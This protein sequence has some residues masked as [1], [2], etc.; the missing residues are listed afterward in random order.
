MEIWNQ[1]YYMHWYKSSWNHYTYKKQQ[2]HIRLHRLYNGSQKPSSLHECSLGYQFVSEQLQHVPVSVRHCELPVLTG[3]GWVGW[4]ASDAPHHLPSCKHSIKG[5]L[6]GLKRGAHHSAH[7]RGLTRRTGQ[8]AAVSF[9]DAC[10]L[11]VVHV[12]SCRRT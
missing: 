4:V 2:H 5:I 8:W 6:G 1:C 12:V 9:Q 11:P 7:G 10:A 3:L